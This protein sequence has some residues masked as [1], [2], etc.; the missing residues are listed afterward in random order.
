VKKKSPKRWCIG[1]RG[2]VATQWGQTVPHGEPERRQEPDAH[3][4]KEVETERE[5]CGGEEPE[6]EAAREGG[7]QR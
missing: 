1:V 2:S 4:E 3:S 6:R 7:S 5:M